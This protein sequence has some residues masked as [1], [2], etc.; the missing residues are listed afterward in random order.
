M[1][2][3]WCPRI[4]VLVV[5]QGDALVPSQPKRTNAGVKAEICELSKG[6]S[7]GVKATK[8][9]IAE[10]ATLAGQLQDKEASAVG[11][12]RLIHTTTTGPSAG[13]LGPFIGDV[14]QIIY[15]NQTYINELKLGPIEARLCAT[16]EPT[17]ENEK[18]WQVIFKTIT[19]FIGPFAVASKPVNGRG[20]WKLNF[21][22]DDFRVLYARGQ[23]RDEENIYILKRV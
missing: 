5:L 14:F 9:T 15:A 11:R 12:W 13:Q 17:S 7:N 23:S 22:D 6:T 19:F 3:I 21:I 1:S 18:E 10:I 20:I 2:L 8:A 16:W 4:L